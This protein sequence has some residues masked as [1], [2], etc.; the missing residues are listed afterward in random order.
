MN[1]LLLAGLFV[2]ASVGLGQAWD[3]DIYSSY[4]LSNGSATIF[5][6]GGYIKGIALSSASVSHTYGN[7]WTIAYD[8][9]T[10]AGAVV[11]G[12]TSDNTIMFPRL[13][14]STPTAGIDK[15]IGEP[16]WF[17]EPGLFVENGLFVYKN[18]AVSGETN[19]VIIYYK[20]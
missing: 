9:V 2:L 3:K 11:S 13:F 5:T 7:S 18:V 6:G 20:R 8:T 17:P 14:T 4:I 10:I 1:K 15:A 12:M 19:K 16:Y